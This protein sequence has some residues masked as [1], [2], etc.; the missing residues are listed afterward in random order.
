[1]GIIAE[2]QK[3]RR[4]ATQQR[5]QNTNK[6]TQSNTNYTMAKKYQ[7]TE[8]SLYDDIHLKNATKPEPPQLFS[9]IASYVKQY[10]QGIDPNKYVTRQMVV[11]IC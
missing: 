7:G 8:E 10:Q 3:L 11:L 6:S 5:K 1:L 9:L 2:S 4:K